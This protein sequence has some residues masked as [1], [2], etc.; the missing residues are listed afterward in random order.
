ME[1]SISRL[2]VSFL[3][4]YNIMLSK[5]HSIKIYIRDTVK[6]IPVLPN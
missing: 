6:A 2:E 4:A 5:T 1:G 3:E